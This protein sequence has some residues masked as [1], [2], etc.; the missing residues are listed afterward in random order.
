MS[1]MNVKKSS[2]PMQIY[3]NIL[4]MQDT[5]NV[6]TV[7]TYSVLLLPSPLIETTCTSRINNKTQLEGLLNAA[8]DT[9]N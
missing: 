6:V 7:L 1:A 3:Y 9:K 4:E 2:K 8:V 5:F